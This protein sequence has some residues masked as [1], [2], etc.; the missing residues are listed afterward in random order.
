MQESN[1]IDVF[2][3]SSKDFKSDSFDSD[4]IRRDI[5]SSLELN[6]IK[7]IKNPI[8]EN[9]KIVHFVT[10]DDI[11]K[12]NYFR[13]KEIKK[14]LSLFDREANVKNRLFCLEK[15]KDKE[16]FHIA[17]RNVDI[18]NKL[19]LLL[20]P[21]NDAKNLL[22]NEGITTRIEVILPLVRLAKTNLEGTELKDVAFR[23]FHFEKSTDYIVVFLD[24][25]SEQSAKNILTLA[26]E[27]PGLRFIVFYVNLRD[28]NQKAMKKIF[29]K[30]PWNITICSSV[31]EDIYYSSL[32]NAKGVIIANNFPLFSSEI[33]DTFAMKK[34]LL[35]LKD[36]VFSDIAIDKVNSHVYNDFASLEDGLRKLSED[37]L[38]NYSESEYNFAKECRVQL[39][40][41]KLK[42]IYETLL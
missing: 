7:Y 32:Y 26:N 8:D 12:Y 25:S 11:N 9:I 18:L 35:A 23:Y 27:F 17:K 21:S 6:E 3:F 37:A 4:K 10:F 28:R 24:T 34:P 14:V 13:N 5:K 15:Y 36:G 20:V 42:D 40:G 31:E 1:K 19:D 39:A 29:K 33:I 41:K 16:T 2:I 38:E 22:V 30:H